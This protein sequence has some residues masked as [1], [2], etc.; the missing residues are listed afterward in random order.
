[1]TL[2]VDARLTHLGIF[3]DRPE[4]MREFYCDVLRLVVSDTGMGHQFKRR[5]IFMTG[6]P[7]EHHQLVLV[8]REPGDPQAGALF[9]LSFKVTTLD[10]LREVTRRALALGATGLRQINHGNSWSVYFHD[11]DHNFVEIYMDTGWYVPQPFADD[12]P[13]DIPDEELRRRTDE[14]VSQCAGALPQNV[15]SAAI[16]LKLAAAN[17]G[18]RQP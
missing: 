11:P 18:V 3:T 12:L 9:Q 10:G 6:N 5:I 8:V 4:A 2:T 14:R 13:L 17:A 7:A 15:W 1:M 16:A